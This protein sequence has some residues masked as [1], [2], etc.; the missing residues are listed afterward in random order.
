MIYGSYVIF[1]KHFW[2]YLRY[3]MYATRMKRGFL[4]WYDHV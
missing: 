3:L 4:I 1:V 2:G